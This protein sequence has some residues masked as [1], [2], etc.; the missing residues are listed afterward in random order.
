MDEVI[1]RKK[2]YRAKRKEKK[3]EYC[4]SFIE[5]SSSSHCHYDQ[6]IHMIKG[7]SL[8]KKAGNDI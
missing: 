8:E 7:N 6:Y 2:K 1:S 5:V 3:E 4:Y